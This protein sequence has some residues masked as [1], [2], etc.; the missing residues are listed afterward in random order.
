MKPSEQFQN[1]R[2]RGKIVG[3][4]KINILNTHT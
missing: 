1:R 4:S 2:N 3:G